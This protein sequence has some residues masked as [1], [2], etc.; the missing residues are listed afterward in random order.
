MQKEPNL[1][2]PGSCV[3]DAWA[4]INDR[5]KSN[6]SSFYGGGRVSLK[7][8]ILANLLHKRHRYFSLFFA[9][10]CARKSIEN[11]SNLFKIQ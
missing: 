4:A 10:V 5:L 7:L 8:I 9:N 6:L 11:P 1:F 2:F 3:Y